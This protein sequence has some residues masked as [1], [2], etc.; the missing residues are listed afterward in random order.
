MIRHAWHFYYASVLMI[1]VVCGGIG[2]AC[3]TP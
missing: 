1:K 2:I 3:L